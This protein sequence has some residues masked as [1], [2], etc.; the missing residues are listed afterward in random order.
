M[1]H[2]RL[3]LVVTDNGAAASN[4]APTEQ[5]MAPSVPNSDLP[6][7]SLVNPEDAPFPDDAA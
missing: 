2:T 4:D 3:K 6:R 7:L 1:A 5:P